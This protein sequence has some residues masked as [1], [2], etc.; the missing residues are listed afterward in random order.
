MDLARGMVAACAGNYPL[1][2]A[3]CEA[4]LGDKK[5]FPRH[6]IEAAKD[7]THDVCYWPKADMGVCAAHVCF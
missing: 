1:R 6:I 5:R 2:F 3:R 7:G 4:L